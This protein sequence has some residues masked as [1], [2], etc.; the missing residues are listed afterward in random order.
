MASHVKTNHALGHLVAVVSTTGDVTLQLA[1]G[2]VTNFPAAPNRL[3]V[4]NN[5]LS[6]GNPSGTTQREWMYYNAK[7]NGLDQI[8]IVAGS[9]GIRGD[10]GSTAQIFQ[11]LPLTENGIPRYSVA[12]PL[13]AADFNEGRCFDN[14]GTF[15][16]NIDGTNRVTIR[17]R[18]GSSPA[19][20]RFED[21]VGTVKGYLFHDAA[22]NTYRFAS[23][24]GVEF[25]LYADEHLLIAGF[26]DGASDGHLEM[27]EA[28]IGTCFLTLGHDAGGTWP[29][30]VSRE[31]SAGSIVAFYYDRALRGDYVLS[32]AELDIRA[33]NGAFLT[34]STNGANERMRIADAGTVHIGSGSDDL[35]SAGLAVEA[36]G[37][38]PLAVNRETDDGTLVSLQQA[39][40]EEGA[41]SVSGATV[42]YGNFAGE[43]PTQRRGQN[44]DRKLPVGSVMVATGQIV[45]SK[46]VYFEEEVVEEVPAN[47]A[48]DQARAKDAPKNDPDPPNTRDPEPTERRRIIKHA[49]DG[50]GR[51]RVELDVSGIDRKGYFPFV[52]RTD[53][54]GDK[55][56]YG[57]YNRIITGG[58]RAQAFGEEGETVHGVMSLG[59]FKI[60]VTDL[61]GAIENG[62]YLE[63][64]TRRGEAQRQTEGTLMNKTVAKALVD[65]DW[66]SVTSDPDLGY[67]LKLIPATL[68]CG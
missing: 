47:S 23:E 48:P 30:A 44:K 62:D 42:T 5:R 57:V 43:H 28:Q 16:V 12:A 66:A 25:R 41:I 46:R 1:S 13:S 55:R 36:A 26:D 52:T 22:S 67:K 61:N 39:G 53:Q 10:Q 33:Y 24:N 11:D 2:Q 37:D 15:L 3:L 38:T 4:W 32:N 64:S 18:V 60:R 31:A 20:L 63:S 49:I 50:P 58:K 56:A 51:T 27:G 34:F 19:Q 54:A 59:L 40:V 7:D 35:G 14:E 65:V 9:G 17:D 68:H 45:Q 29:L 21:N 6:P 8:S